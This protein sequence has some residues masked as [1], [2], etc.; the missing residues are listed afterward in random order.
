MELKNS[1]SILMSK[2]NITYRLI[3]YVFISM[4]IMVS[5]GIGIFIPIVKNLFSSIEG[6]EI[7]ATA[8]A[9]S[10]A[11]LEGEITIKA[12]IEAIKGCYES[13]VLLINSSKVPFAFWTI[14]IVMTFLIRFAIATAYPII[15]DIENS[16]MSSNMNYG[17]ISCMVKE[18]KNSLKYSLF[19]TAITVPI[20]LIIIFLVVN[21]LSITIGALSVFSLIFGLLIAIG[22]FSAR[23]TLFAGVLPVM[24]VEGEKS[25]FKALK[26]SWAITQSYNKTFF[27]ALCVTL[28]VV[29]CLSTALTLPTFG[30]ATIVLVAMGLTF[31]RILEL[32]CYYGSKKQRYYIDANPIVN[33]APII[34]RIDCITNT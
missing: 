19:Y 26:K 14:I 24:I 6:E 7:F 27:G 13:F 32:V 20:D 31:V 12:F 29:Y 33:T 28:F 8:N 25:F 21:F 10:K 22:L 18:I 15:T 11:L 2:F 16:F 4:T 3:V 30:V 34:E 1:L 9:A 5:I 17:F 23:I